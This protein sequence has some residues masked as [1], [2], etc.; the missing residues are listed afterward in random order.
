MQNMDTPQPTVSNLEPGVYTFVLK[1]TDKNGQ[2]NEDEVVVYVKPEPEQEKPTSEKEEA[3]K[4]KP[5]SAKEKD[6]PKPAKTE[7]TPKPEESVEQSDL[8]PFANAGEDISITLPDNEVTLNGKLSSDDIGIVNW[9][10]TRKQVSQMMKVCH[11]TT[12]APDICI[13]LKPKFK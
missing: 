13:L 10:W 6:E 9:E 3:S 7:E 2:T 12:F 11:T 8:P 4:E 1:A 5:V